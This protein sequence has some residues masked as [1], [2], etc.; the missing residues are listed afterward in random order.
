MEY[1]AL[2]GQK[3]IE[4]WQGNLNGRDHIEDSG[5]YTRK[6]LSSILKKKTD[7]YWIHMA[8]DGGHYQASVNPVMNL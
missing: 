5:I 2:M 6:W 1:V 8:Q 7:V 3:H 4:F